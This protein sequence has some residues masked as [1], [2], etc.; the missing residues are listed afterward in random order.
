MYL[1]GNLQVMFDALYQLGVIEP[2]LKKSWKE[3]YVE[4]SKHQEQLDRVFNVVNTCQTSAEDLTQQLRFFNNEILEFLAI[5]VA[6]EFADF[7]QRQEVH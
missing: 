6:K 5:E 2:L 7:H 4:F 3:K 1:K